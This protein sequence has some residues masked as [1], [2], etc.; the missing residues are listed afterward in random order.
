VLARDA[1]RCG[2]LCEASFVRLSQ[3]RQ[4]LAKGQCSTVERSQERIGIRVT[5]LSF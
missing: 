2:K 4:K 1:Q 3:R 5:L